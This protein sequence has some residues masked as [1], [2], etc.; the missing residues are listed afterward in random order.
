M[1]TKKYAIKKILNNGLSYFYLKYI[2]DKLR[3]KIDI[4]QYLKDTYNMFY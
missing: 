1:N 2:L 4:T 3:T